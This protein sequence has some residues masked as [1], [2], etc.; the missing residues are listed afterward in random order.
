MERLFMIGLSLYLIA[1]LLFLSLF[2]L[3]ITIQQNE[4]N[5]SA[6]STKIDRT[7][8]ALYNADYQL[9]KA[10]IVQTQYITLLKFQEINKTEEAFWNDVIHN[11]SEA[12]DSAVAD[13][14]R[15]YYLILNGKTPSENEVRSFL[16]KSI[17]ERNKIF[18]SLTEDCSEKLNGTVEKKKGL[19]NDNSFLMSIKNDLFVLVFILQSLSFF[20]LLFSERWRTP[21]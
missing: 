21:I 5:I 19:E 18:E 1:F 9:T 20:L 17:P 15:Q 2:G 12:Y 7:W 13:S 4:N 14:Y 11:K 6:L 16:E 3:E 10:L 8:F